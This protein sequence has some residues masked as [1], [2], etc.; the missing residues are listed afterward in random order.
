MSSSIS[1]TGNMYVL[2]REENE[3]WGFIIKFCHYKKQDNKAHE[4][5]I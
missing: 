5:Q 4:I 2:P 3:K 1:K